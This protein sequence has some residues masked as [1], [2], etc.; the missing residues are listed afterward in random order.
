M[1]IK[2]MKIKSV[3]T[4]RF[5]TLALSVWI[6]GLGDCVAYNITP[7]IN[8]SQPVDI[9]SSAISSYNY[10]DPQ[11]ALSSDGNT[12]ISVWVAFNDIDSYVIRCASATISGN[13][14]TWG[15]PVEISAPIDGNAEAPQVS[16]SENGKQAA[17][18]WSSRS[19]T[20]ITKFASGLINGATS[21]WSK[22]VSLSEYTSFFGGSN[23]AISSDGRKVT[24]V[25]QELSSNKYNIKSKSGVIAD[26][27]VHWGDVATVPISIGEPSDAQL[28]L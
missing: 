12:A 18:V 21:Q 10:G 23:L 13:V 16:I 15:P 6:Y 3:T 26:N 8:C 28:G 11:L 24:V 5:F 27:L 14:A 19:N 9:V 4:L 1:F 20:I 2:I 22:T 25:W 17:I 7:I